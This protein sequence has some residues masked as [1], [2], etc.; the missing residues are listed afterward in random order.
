[1]T[2]ALEELYAKLHT[3]EVTS[4]VGAYDYLG[5]EFNK[6]DMEGTLEFVLTKEGMKNINKEFKLLKKY[7]KG[8][9]DLNPKDIYEKYDEGTEEYYFLKFLVVLM[10]LNAH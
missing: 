3:I 4:I 10:D 9:I 6:L 2:K 1:M 5:N 7:Y 8:K